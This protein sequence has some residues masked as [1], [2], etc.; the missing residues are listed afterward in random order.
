MARKKRTTTAA[1]DVLEFH[2]MHACAVRTDLRFV[3]SLYIRV[4]IKLKT[5]STKIDSDDKEKKKKKRVYP[6]SSCA[7]GR[8]YKVTLGGY[9]SDDD[10]RYVYSY[11]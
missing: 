9:K 6:F 10:L 11:T 4:S 8:I 7:L 2:E 1:T 3:E 5:F